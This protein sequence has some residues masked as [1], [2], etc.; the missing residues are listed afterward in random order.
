V[1]KREGFE[2]GREEGIE[3][4]IEESLSAAR[5]VLVHHLERR[6]GTLPSRALAKL[7]GFDS[8]A[9]LLELSFA[10]PGASSLA[11]LGLE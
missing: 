1:W 3:K 7:E 5:E 11:A 8:V 2:E 10:V 4:G 6:F 9:A